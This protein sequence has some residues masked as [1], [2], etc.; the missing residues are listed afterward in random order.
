MCS[1]KHEKESLR[2]R[3][4]GTR[5]EV[6]HT[7]AKTTRRATTKVNIKGGVNTLFFVTPFFHPAI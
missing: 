7:K 4:K 1:T 2:L 5:Q 6:S 3:W